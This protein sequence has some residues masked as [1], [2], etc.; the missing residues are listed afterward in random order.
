MMAGR[1]CT[2]G[3]VITGVT[4]RKNFREGEEEACEE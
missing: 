3:N 1:G 2:L 4:T